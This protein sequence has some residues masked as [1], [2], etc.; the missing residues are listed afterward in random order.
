MSTL[1][2][3]GSHYYINIKSSHIKKSDLEYMLSCSVL[4]LTLSLLLFS[5]ISVFLN[6]LSSAIE[7]EEKHVSQKLFFY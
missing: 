7:N 2:H 1:S 6:C 3:S 5:V 4:L